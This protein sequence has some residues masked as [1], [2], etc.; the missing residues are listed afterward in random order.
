[1]LALVVAS[2]T[3]K[4]IA[5]MFHPTTHN[6]GLKKSKAIILPKTRAS[7]YSHHSS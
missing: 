5:N 1:M 2:T 6:V 3:L 4:A 7:Y